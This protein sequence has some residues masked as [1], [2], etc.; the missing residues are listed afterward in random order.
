MCKIVEVLPEE[1]GI[2]MNNSWQT[3]IICLL[4]RVKVFSRISEDYN[5]LELVLLVH[6]VQ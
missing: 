5:M 2:M 4:T 6:L 3:N 1:D